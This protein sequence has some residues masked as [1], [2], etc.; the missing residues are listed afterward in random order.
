MSVHH[1]VVVVYFSQLKRG[2]D[3]TSF[4]ANNDQQEWEEDGW[5]VEWA[6]IH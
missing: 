6:Y 1:G 4:A 2:S 3:L 5:W